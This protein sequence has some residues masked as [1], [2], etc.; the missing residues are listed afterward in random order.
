MRLY[1]IRHAEPD[2]PNN[3]ITAAGHREAQALSRRLAREDLHHVYS[4]PLGRA[5][6][7][8]RYTAELVKLEPRMEDWLRELPGCAMDFPSYGRFAIW[9]APGELLRAP[10]PFPSQA[11]WPE[12]EP[13]GQPPV[14]EACAA[15][16]AASDAFLARHGY[17]RREGRYACARPNRDRIAVFCH[18][19]LTLTWLSHLLEIPLPMMWCGFF[20]PASS[21]TTVLFEERSAEWA[22]PRCLGLGD[23]GHLHAE[24]LPV[25]NAGICANWD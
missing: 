13:F 8:M 5:L 9:N 19:G 1:L 20:L 10:R 16:R 7:T 4:S 22:A 21:V 18:L 17:E 25:S 6:D 24:G 14:R 12:Y 11:L 3:T 23:V 2:Y 15:L